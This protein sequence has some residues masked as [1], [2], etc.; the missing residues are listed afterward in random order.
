MSGANLDAISTARS[1]F[2][3][4]AWASALPS[5]LPSAPRIWVNTGTE[6]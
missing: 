6:A 4:A 2:L 1:I 5:T 3:A